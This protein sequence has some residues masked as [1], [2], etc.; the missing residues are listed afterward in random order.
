MTNSRLTDPE[1]IE[2]RL[3]VRIQQM[4]I[5]TGSGGAGLQRGG[6]GLI[7]EI[8]FLEEM[9]LSILSSGRRE[10]PRGLGGGE[11]GAPGCNTLID[12][13]ASTPLPARVSQQVT[14][15][16]RLRI[17]TPG[18]GGYGSRSP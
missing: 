8:E 11:P 7:R 13:G 2:G 5:R 14:V 18:G 1:V 3:P 4:A 15:G 9:Q 12:G 17:E 16:Q 10:G 6:D